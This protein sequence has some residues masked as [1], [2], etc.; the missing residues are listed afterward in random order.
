M[1]RATNFGQ[2]GRKQPGMTSHLLGEGIVAGV[3]YKERDRRF[4]PQIA[5]SMA[6]PKEI[7]GEWAAEVVSQGEVT[8]SKRPGNDGGGAIVATKLS[9]YRFVRS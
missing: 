5:M 2:T 4:E 9:P 6:L 3:A 8:R 1:A 7:T